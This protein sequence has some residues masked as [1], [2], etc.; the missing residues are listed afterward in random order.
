VTNTLRRELNEE[1]DRGEKK[2]GR[3]SEPFPVWGMMRAG[4]R[5]RKRPNL[6]L[7]REEKLTE[8]SPI[9]EGTKEVSGRG[10]RLTS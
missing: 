2:R 6:L 9:E 3:P 4:K 5:S 8:K 7:R 1:I 10:S